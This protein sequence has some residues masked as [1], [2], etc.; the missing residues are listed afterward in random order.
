MQEGPFGL[1]LELNSFAHYWNGLPKLEENV[2]WNLVGSRQGCLNRVKEGI[3]CKPP[4]NNDGN[5]H[6][7]YTILPFYIPSPLMKYPPFCVVI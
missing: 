2:K 3:H 1:R 4:R 5:V 7:A 6:F